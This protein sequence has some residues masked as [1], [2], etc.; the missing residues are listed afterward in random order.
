MPSL[1]NGLFKRGCKPE[2]SES[3]LFNLETRMRIS[4]IQSRTSRRDREFMTLNLRL[5]DK[6]EKK[7]PP[8]LGIVTRSRFIISILRLPDE[9]ESFLDMISGFET[10]ARILKV[11]ICSALQSTICLMFSHF[12]VTQSCS[13]SAYAVI[14]TTVANCHGSH[15]IECFESSG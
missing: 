15:K 4:P 11:A 3:H 6:T 8:I 14:F 12:E 10:G 1:K 9:N 7:S 2:V 13:L 5:R